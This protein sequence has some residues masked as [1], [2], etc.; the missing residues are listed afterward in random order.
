MEALRWLA[1]VDVAGI[2][3][4]GMALGFSRSVTYSHVAR[5]ERAGLLV[6]AFAHGGSVVAITARG[7]RA[8]GADRAKTRAG[9]THGEGLRHARAVSW[10]AALLSLR[11]RDWVGARAMRLCPEWVVPVLWAAHRGAH[12]P[13][14]GIVTPSG[15]L[16]AV[17]VELSHKSPRRFD[18]L[19]AGYEL[20]IARGVIGGGLIYVSDRADVL[21]AVTRAALRSGVPESRFRA[22]ALDD[23][24]QEAR[25]AT[26]SAWPRPA[27]SERTRGLG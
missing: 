14:L 26:S 22:R 21:A 20:S 12:R 13:S 2:E 17:E 15:R 4:L 10:I 23:V 11:D 3:A 25:R 9:A 5:L 18:A 27:T 6:R 16:V 19:M 7:R 1:R 8:V 24:I